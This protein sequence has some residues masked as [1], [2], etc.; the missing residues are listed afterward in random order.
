[1]PSAQAER[2]VAAVL[3]VAFGLEAAQDPAEGVPEALELADPPLR[4][5][6]LSP[7]GGGEL[8]VVRPAAS[9]GH[10]EELPGLGQA[11]AEE[12]RPEDPVDPPEG[13]LVVEPVAGGGAAAGSTS[14]SLS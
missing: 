2:L 13:L 8:G 5:G 4:L 12:L 14:P 10:V 7:D 6:E 1:M 3:P 11:Q 9:L